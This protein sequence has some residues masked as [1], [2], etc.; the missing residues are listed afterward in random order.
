MTNFLK[1]AY[2]ISDL[3]YDVYIFK[4]NFGC[5]TILF[6]DHKTGHIYN[7]TYFHYS[8]D[9]DPKYEGDFAFGCVEID[10]DNKQPNQPCFGGYTYGCLVYKGGRLRIENENLK[11]FLD[12]ILSDMENFYTMENCLYPPYK[13]ESLSEQDIATLGYSLGFRY[14]Y[15]I[16]LTVC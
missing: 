13:A 2:A 5:K 14:K 12:D 7:C 3:G 4:T 10:L 1:M 11:D 9:T 6:V 15:K 8:Y 16:D